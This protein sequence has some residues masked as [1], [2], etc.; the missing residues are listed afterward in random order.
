MA[1]TYAYHPGNVAHSSAM[2]IEDTIPL[3]ARSLGIDLIPLDGA[4]SCG[5][6][7]IRQANRRLQLTLNARTF[8]MAEALGLEILTPCAATAGNLCEDLDELRRNPDLLADVNRT[9]HSTCDMQFSGGTEVRHLMHVIVEDIGL[10]KLEEKVVNPLDFKI[11]GYYGPNIQRK[12][13]CGL[14]DVF[15][16]NYLENV[17]DAVGGTPISLDSRT[18][19]VGVPSLLSEE[20]TALKQA[21]GVLSEAVDE[22]AELLVSICNLSH[23][24]LDVYQV[25][26]SRISGLETRIPVIHFTDMLAYSFGHLNT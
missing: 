21:A 26:A 5:A 3:I 10:E 18:Q 20:S 24:V 2:E 13:A 9:L 22:G 17:I 12:G 25:K 6:G 4:T 11:S 7:I 16:P 8:A 19:S 15:L 14:D 1:S 23:A